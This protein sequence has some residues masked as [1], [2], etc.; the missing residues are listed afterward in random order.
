MALSPK[1][2][3]FFI[4]AGAAAALVLLFAFWT[5]I[6]NSLGFLGKNAGEIKTIEQSDAA[7]DEVVNAEVLETE[8]S[9]LPFHK[10]PLERRVTK[11]KMKL[12]GQGIMWSASSPFLAANGGEYTKVGSYF[13]ELGAQYKAPFILKLGRQDDYMVQ[14]DNLVTFA[15]EYIQSGGKETDQGQAF[16]WFMGDNAEVYMTQLNKKLAAVAKDLELKEGEEL[17]GEGFVI[18]G[19]SF[20]EDKAM[21]PVEWHDDPTKALGEVF[22]CY[23]Q[24][25]DQNLVIKWATDNGLPINPDGSTYCAEAVNFYF[26]D[27]FMQAAEALGTMT[28]DRMVVTI[29]PKTGKTR[30]TSGTKSVMIRGTATWTPGDELAFNKAKREGVDLVSLYS[31]KDNAHQM[32]C[33]IV[34]LNK[35]ADDHPEVIDVITEGTLRYGDQMKVH[36]KAFD[37]AMECMTDVYK[38]K[39]TDYWGT[40]FRGKLEKTPGGHEVVLGGTRVCNLA[41]NLDAFGIGEGA[42]NTYQSSYELFGGFIHTLY[43]EYMP[44]RLSFFKAMSTDALNRV[45][46]KM[47]KTNE[48]KTEADR[49]TFETGAITEKVAER[50]YSIEF[51]TGSDKLTSKGLQTVQE[52]YNGLNTNDLRITIA[53]HTDSQGNDAVNQPLSEQR[54]RAVANWLRNKNKASFPDERFSEIRGYG[55]SKPIDDNTTSAGR[56][57][58]RRVDITVGN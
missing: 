51:E 42:R 6:S 30:K 57:R 40:Y 24:D 23:P 58:N 3:R 13:D 18:P 47:A 46:S 54:A 28:G 35:F 45:A 12:N 19:Y 53:G 37:F 14:Q 34:T 56:A 25:G 20:G 36:D 49:P 4:F 26:T 17:L 21:G 7:V 33:I 2:K 31:T 43:P 22:A 44:E 48:P 11:P 9:D 38:F 39:T 52:L 8:V 50:S 41:D 5:P 27:G 55:A 32:P 16:V 10:L 15:K 29:D 1:G